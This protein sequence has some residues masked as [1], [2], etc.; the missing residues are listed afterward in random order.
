LGQDELSLRAGLRNLRKEEINRPGE[1]TII[2]KE[3]RCAGV[4]R[5]ES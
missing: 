5:P 4:W 1:D 3:Q 2:F